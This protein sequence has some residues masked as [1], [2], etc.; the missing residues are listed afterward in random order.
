MVFWIYNILNSL[1]R[2]FT[3][4]T[5]KRYSSYTFSLLLCYYLPLNLI[6]RVV[7]LPQFYVAFLYCSQYYSITLL[8]TSFVILT[9]FDFL[10]MSSYQHFK[11]FQILTIY[12]HQL[13]LSTYPSFYSAL[14][15]IMRLTLKYSFLWL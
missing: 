7:F 14:Y 8:S 9:I 6:M 5:T 15:H 10:Q 13:I 11:L 12:F 2:S 3:L 1:C 4:T